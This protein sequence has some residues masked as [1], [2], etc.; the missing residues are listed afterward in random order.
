MPRP[1]LP[2]TPTTV[3]R[4]RRIALAILAVALLDAAPLAA[5]H[6]QCRPPR[7]FDLPRVEADAPRRVL[8]VTGYTLALSWS[9][10][11]CKPRKRQPSHARQCSG[12]AGLFGLVV[13]GLWP[14]SGRSWPQWCSATRDPLPREAAA[15][16]CLTPSAALLA[17]QW[18]KHGACMTKRP[19]TYFKVTRILWQG[20][21]IPDLD[22]VSREDG[23]TA[24]TIRARFT[25]ANP[26]W[27]REAVG[28]HL[29]ARGWLEELQLCY[30]KR[31]MPVACDRRRFGAR[32]DTNAKI[33]RGL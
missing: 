17:R 7:S 6:Y 3:R 8:P 27:P 13:H 24:G 21:R 5:Q 19:A 11:F 20:L 30:D 29:N 32:D 31:F 25:D 1:G 15:N 18:A 2:K 22:R 4:P 9:P 26:D 33:W 28:V 16:M 23:L 14:E 10:E 12:Q